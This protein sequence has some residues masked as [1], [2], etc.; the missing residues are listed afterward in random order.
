[1]ERAMALTLAITGGTGFVGR[2]VLEAALAR[3]HAVRALTRRPQPPRAGIEW[4]PGR[5]ESLDSLRAL[6]RGA[7]ALVHVAGVTNARDR[8]GFESGNILGTAAVRAAAGARPLLLVS[9]LAAREPAL[10]VYGETKRRAEDVARGAAGPVAILRPSA[11]YGPFDTEFLALFRAARGG[12]VPVPAR[13]VAAMIFAADLARAIVALA[14]DLAGAGA[15]AGQT[16][17]IDD[18]SGG[19]PQ[20]AIAAAIGAAVGRTVVA[21]PVPRPL[22]L[23]GA[24]LDTALARASGRLPRLSFDRA[25][26]L[27]HPD[28]S[29][30]SRPLLALGLWAPTTALAE[31]MRAT[32]DWYRAQ[33]LLPPLRR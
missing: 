31:G 3:G 32:A 14:E 5:L 18:G 25:R 9:S 29:A 12:V 7:D 11:V 19:H 8:R 15:S 13:G 24:A 33:G 27:P 26:Y 20:A 23:L 28:W 30:D 21:L 4:V 10:S 6:A 17:E 22:F 1:M 2:H 16:L